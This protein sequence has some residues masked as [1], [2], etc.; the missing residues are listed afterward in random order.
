MKTQNQDKA[1]ANPLTCFTAKSRAFYDRSKN[2]SMKFE[3]DDK[4]FDAKSEHAALLAVV[5][6]A[7]EFERIA[8]SE[9][10]LC[11]NYILAGLKLR[12]TLA[13]LAAVY[14]QSATKP[15]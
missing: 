12:S 15:T 14:K 6:A 9:Q 13:N 1:A 11:P 5:E 8:S 2:L 7:K 4:I 10:A 3:D